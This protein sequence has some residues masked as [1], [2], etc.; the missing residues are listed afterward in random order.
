MPEQIMTLGQITKRYV[1]RGKETTLIPDFRE[2][3]FYCHFVDGAV[4]GTPKIRIAVSEIGKG[5]PD[6]I[7]IELIPPERSAIELNTRPDTFTVSLR[8]GPLPRRFATAGSSREFQVALRSA[9]PIW[10]PFDFNIGQPGD[11]IFD[12]PFPD[13]PDPLPPGGGGGPNQEVVV[14]TL[15]PGNDPQG[16]WR[17][18]LHNLSQQQA[19]FSINIEFPETVQALET[20]RIPFQLLNRTF[21]EFM[22]LMSLRLHIDNG[23]ASIRFSPEFRKLAGIDDITVSVND[24][25]QNI[26]LETF[27]IR[28]G[29]D[30][31]FGWPLLL[32][33]IDLEER[34]DEVGLPLWDGNIEDLSIQVAFSFHLFEPQITDFF[35]TALLRKNGTIYPRNMPITA[36]VY[37]NPDLTGIWASILDWLQDFF[38]GQSFSETVEDMRLKFQGAL[39]DAIDDGIGDYFRET[40]VHL[41]QRDHAIHSLNCDVNDLIIKH[42]EL[43][44]PL[45]D[46]LTIPGNG[47]VATTVTDATSETDSRSPASLAQTESNVHIEGIPPVV[48]PATITNSH[49]RLRE[50]EIDHIVFLM[51]ENRSFDHMLGYLALKGRPVR[52]LTGSEQNQLPE[53]NPPYIVNHLSRTYG[54]PSPGHDFLDA[55]EQI[56]EGEMSGFVKNFVRRSNVT[57]PSMV[58]GYYQEE[59]LP[60]YE[61]FA[62]NFAICDAWFSSHPGA[63]WPN[64]FCATTGTAPE[65]DNFDVTDERLGYY[66]GLSIFDLLTAFGV[67]WTYAEGNIGFLRLFDRYRLDTE[68]VIPYR[69]DF[70]LGLSDTF[71]QRV[72]SGNLPAVSFIDPR[73]F[74]IP[75]AWDAND[76]LPPTDVC[77]GQALIK[78]IYDMLSKAPTWSKTLFVIT[79]DEHGGFFDHVPPPGTPASENPAPLPRITP[80]GADH[81]GV[82]VP[83]FLVSPWVDAGSVITTQFEHTSILKTILERFGSTEYANS[84][85]LGARTAQSNSLLSVLRSTPRTDTPEAPEVVCE[86]RAIPRGPA[87][88]DD[89]HTGL[90]Y[91]GLPAS[92]RRRLVK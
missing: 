3:P 77:Y 27:Q 22:L 57:D 6:E 24:R 56:A 19:E 62:N 7:L 69:D 43:P 53:G 18:R 58:M 29:K 64:R 80:E 12:D 65:R 83:A 41:V 33:G 39:N 37:T 54:I 60:V 32:I 50:G 35:K 8:H 88:R 23:F 21:A 31:E 45:R 17:V 44:D 68:H 91:L 9:N 85:V 71:I 26:G 84:D 61:F 87:H 5:L 70:G 20:T 82:R 75:P 79:Y 89:F 67:D 10:D 49:H 48:L 40:L 51:M 2:I 52:G 16:L 47:G 74:D 46:Q 34:G 13:I 4:N 86:K 76:D 25:L 55:K 11:L 63:T 30:A 38:G 73:Y 78:E 59:D 36:S 14:H 28:M 15:H 42:H 72:E 1:L 81:L 90:R 66:E 92:L